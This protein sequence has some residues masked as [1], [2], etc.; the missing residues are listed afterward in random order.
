MM[1]H[2]AL[3]AEL[4]MKTIILNWQE[5]IQKGYMKQQEELNRERQIG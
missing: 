5:S 4:R 2:Y 3:K 1:H